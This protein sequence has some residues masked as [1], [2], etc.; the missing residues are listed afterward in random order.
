MNFKQEKKIDIHVDSRFKIQKFSHLPS[1]DV[2]QDVYAPNV[3]LYLEKKKSKL[4]QPKR[5]IDKDS[6]TL[7]SNVGL[8]YVG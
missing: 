4:F 1:Y 7:T 8:V 5:G 6:V 2:H 3:I